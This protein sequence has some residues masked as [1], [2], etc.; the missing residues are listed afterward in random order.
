MRSVETVEMLMVMMIEQDWMNCE[1]RGCL[2][3]RD[4]GCRSHVS[5]YHSSQTSEYE[6]DQNRNDGAEWIHVKG[7]GRRLFAGEQ[8]SEQ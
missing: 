3:I 1:S 5:L 4:A 6:R 7:D 8:G 2:Y